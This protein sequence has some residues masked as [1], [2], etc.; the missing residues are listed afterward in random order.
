MASP[1][2]MHFC[3]SCGRPLI[4]KNVEGHTR[5]FCVACNRA[6]FQD[7]K[8]AAAVLVEHDEKVLLVKRGNAPQRGKWTFPAGFVDAGEDP[9]D[10]AARECQ[11]ETG[12]QIRITAL[13]DV[14]HG[15]EHERGAD[16]VIVYRGEIVEGT[17]NAGDDAQDV[18]FFTPEGIPPIA[19]QVTRTI[20]NQWR[21][22][23]NACGI[24]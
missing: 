12:L 4:R 13:L 6:F 15:K 10:A 3:P 17:L 1:E 2:K 23:I 19:F 21:S 18:A 8:V 11:E 9:Q 7:P 14:I 5:P 24:D 20:L 16:I 22:S